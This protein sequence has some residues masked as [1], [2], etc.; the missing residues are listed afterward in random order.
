MD[1]RDLWRALSRR[2]WAVLGCVALAGVA[3]YGYLAAT[4]AVYQASS[5]IVL[6]ANSP[7]TIGETAQGVSTT[8][9]LAETAATIIDSPALLE[10][11]ATDELSAQQ[12]ADMISVASRTLTSTIDIVAMSDSPA[13]AAQAAN[14]AAQAAR[15]E[16]PAL[17]G[18]DGE[19]GDLPLAVTV[20]RE[21]S[22]PSAPF[23]PDAKGVMVI[24]VALGLCGGIAAALVIDVLR[25]RPA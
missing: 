15:D 22:E 3:A 19:S 11:A 17:L 13:A 6:I 20:L 18:A 24:A 25:R 12:L 16:L 21:A 5:E 2:W 7:T 4:P 8:T 23:S 1:L 14:A 10:A 9:Q